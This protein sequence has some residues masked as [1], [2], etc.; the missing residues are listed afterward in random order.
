M[1]WKVLEG[2]RSEDV[3]KFVVDA[4]GIYTGCG[5]GTRRVVTEICPPQ[6]KGTNR[7]RGCGRR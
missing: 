3:L 1:S 5:S 2:E 6:R 4:S 7:A